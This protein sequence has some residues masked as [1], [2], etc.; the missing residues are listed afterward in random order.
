[1]L[2]SCSVFDQSQ[3]DE[4]M[5]DDKIQSLSQKQSQKKVTEW[6]KVLTTLMEQKM[7]QEKQTHKLK[8]QLEKVSE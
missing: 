5:D 3:K 8:P 4:K 6:E 2:V 7:D 1:M